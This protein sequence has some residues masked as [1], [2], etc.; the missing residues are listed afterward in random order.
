MPLFTNCL[1]E[2]FSETGLPVYGVLGNSVG[3]IRAEYIRPRLFRVVRRYRTNLRTRTLP[4]RRPSP[5][6]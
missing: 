5:I 3:I 1:E 4:T 2:V 6:Y